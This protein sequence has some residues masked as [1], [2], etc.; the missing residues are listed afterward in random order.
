MNEMQKPPVKIWNV[1]NVL[2]LLRMA[3]VPVFMA[4]ALYLPKITVGTRQ[5]TGF[6]IPSI[7]GR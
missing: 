1:P 7:F 2:S 3:L 5:Q 6:E 4:A